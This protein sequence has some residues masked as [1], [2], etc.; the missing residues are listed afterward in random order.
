MIR[1][2]LSLPGYVG[3]KWVKTVLLTGL[4]WVT[5]PAMASSSE[6][7]RGCH[8]SQYKQWQSSDHFHAMQVASET[9][10]LGSFDDQRVAFHGI[11]STFSK[12][13]EGNFN[14][15]TIGNDGTSLSAR[16]SYTFGY[17]PL[18]QYLVELE[19]GHLQALNLAWDTRPLQEGGQR[20]FHLQPDETITPS[21]PFFWARHFSNWNTRCA[22]CHST[23]LVPGYD[24]SSNEFQTTYTEPNVSCEACHRGA[25]RHLELAKTGQLTSGNT[26]YLP[27][28]DGIEW[29]FGKGAAI[30]APVGSLSSTEI[31][32]C[33]GCHSRRSL[34]S[35]GS[36]GDYFDRHDLTLLAD[37]LYFADGQIQDEVFVLGSFLQSKMHQAGVTCSNCHEPHSGQL[38][39]VGN[40]L[41]ATCHAPSVFDGIDHHGHPEGSEGAAC[42]DCHMPARTYMQVDDRRDHRFH[43]PDPLLSLEVG[44]PDPCMNCHED[45]THK[46]AD[47]NIRAWHPEYTRRNIWAEPLSRV[48]SLDASAVDEL[49]SE[50]GR[51]TT[52]PI[53]R[54]TL[55]QQLADWPEPRS[56]AASQKH[57]ASDDPLIRAAAANVVRVAPSEQR[58]RILTP[59]LSDD[60][61]VVRHAAA[62]SLVASPVRLGTGSEMRVVNEYRDALMLS[63]GQPESQ[64]TLADVAM[65][66]GNVKGAESHFRQA[67]RIEPNHPPALLRY[68]DFLRS[69]GRDE[70]AAVHL[71]H[72][73][74]VLPDNAA[75]HHSYGLLLIRQKKLEEAIDHLRQAS[76][77][78]GAIPRY[79][80]VY[81][82]GLE[83][84][85]LYSEALE[86]TREA[87]RQ[88][89]NDLDLLTTEI[90][91]RQRM[92]ETEGLQ[93]LMETLRQRSSM[94]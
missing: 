52:A 51:A 37:G 2:F 33:G 72:A 13:K 27:S 7:C 15:T 66:L 77:Y 32:T 1:G 75:A 59:L 87:R 6:D 18:Q 56:V 26:G 16:V 19:G 25:D 90:R 64:L 70:E 3:P 22:D 46:W 44:S 50:I 94:R 86:V 78:E 58:Q 91:L 35:D 24:A 47:E 68:A 74:T 55:L 67:L 88:W 38:L 76:E 17:T 62:R 49:I 31:D 42:V 12:D 63:A 39:Q 21:H 45:K 28:T 14:V 4:C 81:A 83:T 53:I 84:T 69:V 80:Y 82:V 30:A 93:T 23:N 60:V 48:R 71:R 36:T 89:P 5:T 65:N 57:M 20:W 11:E 79:V 8:E 10:V 61:R 43:V 85:G 54:A 40:D 41:C 73:I 34:I 92:G 29:R 9:S